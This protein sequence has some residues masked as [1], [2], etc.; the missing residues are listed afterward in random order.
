M[1]RKRKDPDH[2]S[3]SFEHVGGRN[4]GIPGGANGMLF[5]PTFSMFA[6][7][8]MNLSPGAGASFPFN[9]GTIYGTNLVTPMVP[10]G[11]DGSVAAFG[12]VYAPAPAGSSAF[13]NSD[14][15][16][17]TEKDEKAENT[18]KGNVSRPFIDF[19]GVGLK[20]QTDHET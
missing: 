15:R 6:R 18:A 10:D 12:N 11:N 3:P 4:I 5:E 20:S 2:S 1:G 17:G 14:F 13:G 9:L 8:D 7:N 19:L 16:F